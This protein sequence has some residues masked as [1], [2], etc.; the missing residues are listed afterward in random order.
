MGI[1]DRVLKGGAAGGALGGPIG[2]GVGVAGGLVGGFLD[3]RQAQEQA[4]AIDAQSEEYQRLLDEMIKNTELPS[5]VAKAY[6]PEEYQLV[7]KY[8]PEIYQQIQEK[9]PDLIPESGMARQAQI[10]ALQKYGQMSV[11]G[12]DAIS[13]AA[14]EQAGFQADAQALQRRQAILQDFARRGMLGQGASFGAELQSSQDVAQQQRQ[15]AIQAQA[16]AQQRR[17]QAL[18][19][20]A[21]TAGTIRQSDNA[22]AAA[23]TDIMNKY[24]ER[25]ANTMNDYNKQ[26]AATLNGAQLTNL[27][28]A[29]NTSDINTQLRNAANLRNLTSQADAE[30]ARRVEKNKLAYAKLTGGRSIA[31]LQQQ[32]TDKRITGTYGALKNTAGVVGGALTTGAGQQTA[33]NSAPAFTDNLKKLGV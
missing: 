8:N 22:L 24:N 21:A 29:Q 17:A 32:G 2:A 20:Y 7:A 3:Y 14:Q 31:D 16:D 25:L 26:K 1:L 19:Q 33:A 18:N 13:Q 4:S 15:A 28:A 6:S 23:N 11:S 9:R 30:E 12:N 5:G 27:S 10:D